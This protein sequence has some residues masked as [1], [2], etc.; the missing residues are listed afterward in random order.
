MNLIGKRFLFGIV[1]MVCVSAVSWHLKYEA[2]V[3]VSLVSSIV[4]MF[5]VSQSVTDMKNGNGQK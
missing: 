1:A 5:M 4:G 2:G 3:Y